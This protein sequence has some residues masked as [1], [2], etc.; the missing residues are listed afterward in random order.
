[1][2]YEMYRLLTSKKVAVSRPK[3][4]KGSDPV[5]IDLVEEEKNTE[6]MISRCQLV[7][8]WCQVIINSCYLM[9]STCISQLVI[10]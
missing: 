9:K 1:M 3:K 4:S 7:I 6:L 8:S 2:G 5:L 10:N